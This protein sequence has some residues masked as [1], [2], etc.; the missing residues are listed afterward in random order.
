MKGG[1][2]YLL[3]GELIKIGQNK[4]TETVSSPRLVNLNTYKLVK[5]CFTQSL[6]EQQRPISV[7][8]KNSLTKLD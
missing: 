7:L 2:F 1:F 4:T 5:A 3:R 6:W 8:F